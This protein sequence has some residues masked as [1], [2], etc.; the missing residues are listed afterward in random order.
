MNVE[1]GDLIA[2]AHESQELP[3]SRGE[4]CVGHHV[5]KPDVQ[6]TNILFESSVRGQNRL[7]LF[8]EAFEGRQI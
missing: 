5:Q 4:G 3:F 2:L 7:S 6:F 8:L 1:L